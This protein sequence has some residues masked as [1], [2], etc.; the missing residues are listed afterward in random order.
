MQAAVFCITQS[1]YIFSNARLGR[2]GS[3]DL[4][5]DLTE[6]KWEPVGQAMDKC[7]KMLLENNGHFR[8]RRNLTDDLC[9]EL[10]GEKRF[11]HLPSQGASSDE[12]ETD[13]EM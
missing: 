7:T 10:E 3:E 12:R 11:H 2:F 5:Q 4:L 13:G 9:S 6:P 1:L 8:T